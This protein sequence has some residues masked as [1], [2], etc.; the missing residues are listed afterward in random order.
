M[1]SNFLSYLYFLHLP[2]YFRYYPQHDALLAKYISK[3]LPRIRDM[4]HNISLYLLTGNVAVDGAKLYP[5]HVIEISELNIKGTNPLDEVGI[6]IFFQ[7]LF[8]KIGSSR[9]LAVIR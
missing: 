4:L 9:V 8:Y 3:P 6:T 1:V 2:L 5:P 7:F